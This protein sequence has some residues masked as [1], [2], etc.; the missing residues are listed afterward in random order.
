MSGDTVIAAPVVREAV[1]NIFNITLTFKE[2]AIELAAM[3]RT[4]SISRA[5][6][7]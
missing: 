3:L 4:N 2:Q 5:S 6:K 7:A 1:E